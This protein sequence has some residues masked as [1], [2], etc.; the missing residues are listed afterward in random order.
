M[1]KKIKNLIAIFGVF[2][3][4][5]SDLFI[6]S[7]QKMKKT[8]RL[9]LCLCV[10]LLAGC[11][12]SVQEQT[13]TGEENSITQEN[14][15]SHENTTMSTKDA[16]KNYL[17]AANTNLTQ[18]VVKSGDRIVVDY[19]GR[20]DDEN[21]FDTSVEAVAKAA[22]KYTPARDYTAG[23]D[24]TVGAGQMIK[25]FDAGVVGMKVGETKTVNIP[26]AEAYGEK[27]PDMII[28]VPLEQAG[29]T[30]GAA[31][32]MKVMLGN[33]YPATITEITD[34]EIVFDMNHELAGKDLI[35]DIT[36][37]KILPPTAQ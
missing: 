32:G 21:V 4:L 37:K 30:S 7:N 16:I 12:Q 11:G 36:I 34:K 20:L 18:E 9:V 26:A 15:L 17:D 29:D 25:G 19:I 31:V 33:M 23:L 10:I 5:H 35:F 13:M 22:G 28:R 3:I 6:L 24:F 1:R 14:V 27:N 8:T 2:Y